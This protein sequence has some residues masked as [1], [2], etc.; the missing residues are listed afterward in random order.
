M[1]TKPTPI[2]E[3]SCTVASLISEARQN[4]LRWLIPGVLIE[5]GQHI[6]HG[7]EESFKTML[8]LQLH[9]VLAV[10][11]EFLGRPVQ[12]GVR[13]GIVQLETKPRIFGGRLATFFKSD[14]PPIHVFPPDK[15]MMLLN[16]KEPR[17]RIA[18]IV[19]WAKRLD[20][21]LVSIDSA[22]KLFP[23]NCD[24]SKPEHASDV[25]NQLQFLP[26]SWMLAHDRKSQNGENGPVGNDEIVGSG[27]F[28]QDPDI[29]YQMVRNDKRE[30]RVEFNWGKVRD[31]EKHGS[32]ELWFD[33]VDFRLH[34]IHPYIHLLRSG[35]KPEQEIVAEALARF[36]WKERTAREH[37]ATLKK[38]TDANGKLAVT[39][40]QE[41]HKKVL[42]LVAE[43]V[44]MEE[45]FN[46]LSLGV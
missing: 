41:G 37:I 46:P 6:L 40:A 22:V 20:L 39:E 17:A 36:S 35:P 34:P 23:P 29:V 14:P 9:E 4:P 3:V 8:T 5:G 32:V 45:E 16:A 11:G 21:Q 7:K 25:F 44:P 24:L 26:T 31:G 1:A 42:T 33:K 30:P 10:G 19:D 18:Q 27:R 38:L 13:T 12:G 28:A 43:P 15:R 2:P